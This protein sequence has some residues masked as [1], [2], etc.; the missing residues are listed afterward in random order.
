MRLGLNREQ[1]H[2]FTIDWVS[3]QGPQGWILQSE[4]GGTEG[5]K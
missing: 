5:Q 2:S 1:Q 3:A 4:G